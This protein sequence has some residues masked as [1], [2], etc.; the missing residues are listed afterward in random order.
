MPVW[1]TVRTVGKLYGFSRHRIFILLEQGAFRSA[2]FKSP[3]SRGQRAIRLIELS[4]VDE[5][6]RR[7]ATEPKTEAA[8]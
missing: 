6:I 1:G 7:H 4:T 8:N 2:L 3:G 5:Y